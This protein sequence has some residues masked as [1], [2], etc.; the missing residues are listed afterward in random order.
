MKHH[1]NKK[2]WSA[3]RAERVFC[4]RCQPSEER[5]GGG[6]QETVVVA[7]THTKKNSPKAQLKTPSHHHTLSL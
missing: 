7:H 2:Q 4:Q 1:S 6:G 5:E 3:L